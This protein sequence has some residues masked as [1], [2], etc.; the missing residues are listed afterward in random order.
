MTGLSGQPPEIAVK[1][2]ELLR[3][4]TPGLERL[5]VLTGTGNPYVAHDVKEVAQGAART[6]NI[7]IQTVELRSGDE[8]DAALSSLE[9]IALVPNHIRIDVASGK[10]RKVLE[11][12]STSTDFSTLLP[13][14]HAEREAAASEIS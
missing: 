5:G 9:F 1:R 14:R 2:I 10:V 4:L 7:E 8:I 11:R 6:F 3:E 12:T 13:Y